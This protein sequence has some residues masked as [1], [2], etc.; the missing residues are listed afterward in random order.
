MKK[1]VLLILV[2]VLS[3]GFD[4][5]S[6]TDSL[7]YDHPLEFFIPGTFSDKLDMDV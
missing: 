2:M 7:R 5:F 3:G 1:V 4:C 6:R